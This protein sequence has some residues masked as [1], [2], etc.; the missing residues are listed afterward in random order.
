MN[1]FDIRW[2]D[3]KT[4]T[5]RPSDPRYAT[6]MNVDLT[7]GQRPFCKAELQYPVPRCGQHVGRCVVCNFLIALM[8]AGR[9]DDPR[10]VKVPCKLW[11]R[12]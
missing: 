9:P 12:A 3:G 8:T 1:R 4:E 11:S 2:M 7:F 5:E 10:T 6:G